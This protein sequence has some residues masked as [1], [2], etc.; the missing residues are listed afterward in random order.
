MVRGGYEFAGRRFEMQR[1]RI[2]FDGSSPPNPQLDILAEANVTGLTARVTVTGSS[3][4]PRIAFTSTPALPEDELLS[5][6]LFGTSITNISAPEAI[7]LGSA[8]ASLRGGGG[9]DPI[10]RLRAA[11]GLDRLRVV[12]ADA[13]IGR[14]T[15]IAVGKYLGRR[16]YAEIITDGRGYSATQLEFRITNWLAVLA[17]VSTVGRESV[18]VRVSRDY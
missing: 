7:Q 4:A 16:F 8:L 5:R 11:I 12:S 15:G 14:S 18:N 10:N 6:L 9:L 17:S 2:T 13:T 3:F 1:G